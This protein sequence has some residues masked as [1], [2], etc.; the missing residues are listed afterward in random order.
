MSNIKNIFIDIKTIFIF[1]GII[2]VNIVHWH[3]II[4][5]LTITI[6]FIDITSYDKYLYHNSDLASV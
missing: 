1:K 2:K 3:F 6:V 4:A 5:H